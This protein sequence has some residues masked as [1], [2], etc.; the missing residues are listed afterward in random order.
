MGG[1]VDGGWI[2]GWVSGEQAGYLARRI[3]GWVGMKDKRIKLK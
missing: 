3:G 2:D 1:W